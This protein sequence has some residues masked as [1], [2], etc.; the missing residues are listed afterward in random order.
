MT[1]T[2]EKLRTT[3]DVMNILGVSNYTIWRYIKSGKLKAVKIGR[4]W[5]IHNDDLQ[6][7]INDP[8]YLLKQK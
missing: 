6:A 3:K 8:N 7:F 5:Y 2:N 4:A 1:N